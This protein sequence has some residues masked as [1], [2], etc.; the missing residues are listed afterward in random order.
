MIINT[1]GHLTEP[2]WPEGSSRFVSILL[3]LF[4]DPRRKQCHQLNPDRR[5]ETRRPLSKRTDSPRG[6]SLRRL[7]NPAGRR[8]ITESG[9]A[10]KQSRPGIQHEMNREERSA[11]DKAKLAGSSGPE[12]VRTPVSPIGRGRVQNILI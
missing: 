5:F 3:S 8:G 7:S 12:G 2:A 11:L 6:L 4:C 9:D 1:L 10:G